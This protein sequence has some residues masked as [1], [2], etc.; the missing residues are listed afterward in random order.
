MKINAAAMRHPRVQWE[1][2][3]ACWRAIE[4]GSAIAMSSAGKEIVTVIHD[5]AQVPALSFW[6]GCQDVSEQVRAIL[7]GQV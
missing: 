6:K 5:R 3:A 2:E 4:C 7:R 1:I